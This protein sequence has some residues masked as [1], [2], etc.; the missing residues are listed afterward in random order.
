MLA[1]GEAAADA[2]AGALVE[3]E[4]A[5]DACV[6]ALGD[7]EA[8]DPLLVVLQAVARVAIIR[9]A[10]MTDTTFLTFF[11]F[12]LLSKSFCEIPR[13]W[14][15]RQLFLIHTDDTKFITQLP[16]KSSYLLVKINRMSLYAAYDV[17]LIISKL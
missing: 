13:I 7:V 11:I 16:M 15:A 17:C 5:A 9:T 6:S 12:Y 3:G 1:E 4:A 8:V 10:K 14:I 2:E